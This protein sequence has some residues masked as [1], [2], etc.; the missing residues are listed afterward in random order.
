[1]ASDSLHCAEMTFDEAL[2]LPN[3]TVVKLADGKTGRM[4]VWHK[5]K[6]AI[7]VEVPGEGLLREVV[8]ARLR[9]EPD[10]TCVELPPAPQ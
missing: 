3:R 2:K 1:M 10:G 9:L 8:P 4:A 6:Q 7:G 5:A